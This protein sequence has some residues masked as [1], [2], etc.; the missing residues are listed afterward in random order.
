[1]A[2]RRLGHV[3]W[4]QARLD[5]SKFVGRITTSLSLV[6]TTEKK[7]FGK[8]QTSTK[9]HLIVL[10]KTLFGYWCQSF[11]IKDRSS[12]ASWIM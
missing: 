8:A 9:K 3:S 10:M 12:W 6:T 7:L 5:A 1:M 4:T 2:K 11:S